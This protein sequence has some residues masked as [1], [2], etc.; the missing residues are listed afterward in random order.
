[1]G[2]CYFMPIFSFIFTDP[3]K[4]LFNK[5]SETKPE[6]LVMEDELGRFALEKENAYWGEVEM[7]GR[8][9]SVCLETDG[10]GQ[11][12]AGKALGSLH[13]FAP[14]V[15]WWDD[16]IKKFAADD[17]AGD[18]G[19][20][21][22]WGGCDDDSEGEIISKEEFMRRMEL[23]FI[24]FYS[25]GGIFLDYDLDEMFTDHGLGVNADISGSIL[26]CALWG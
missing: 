5:K 3:I 11:T 10:D 20:I 9:V 24:Q 12:T 26:S 13:T 19:M 18:D 6:P 17:F 15:K 1:M 23:N 8:K 2:R 14:K 25:D 22:T 4:D 7:L 16:E 21:E